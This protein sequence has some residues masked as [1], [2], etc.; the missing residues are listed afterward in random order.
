MNS[1]K[2]LLLILYSIS[3]VVFSQNYNVEV[4]TELGVNSTGLNI[5][6][7]DNG[8]FRVIGIIDSILNSI[9]FDAGGNVVG[10]KTFTDIDYNILVS[11]LADDGSLYF[12][13]YIYES[14]TTSIYVT[15]LNVEF[16]VLFN[17]KLDVSSPVT[18][19]FNIKSLNNGAILAGLDNSG[20]FYIRIGSNGEI[21]WKRS[22]YEL[23]F[24]PLRLALVELRNK[25]FIITTKRNIYRLNSNG[26]VL[27]NYPNYGKDPQIVELSDSSILVINQNKIFKLSN[28]GVIINEIENDDSNGKLLLTLLDDDNLFLHSVDYHYLRLIDSD[29]NIIWQIPTEASFS[30]A[31]I[32]NGVYYATGTYGNNMAVCTSGINEFNDK[33]IFLLEPNGSEVFL[34]PQ[35]HSFNRNWLAWESNLVDSIIIEYSHDNGLNWQ[36]LTLNYDF[37]ARYYYIDEP[38]V[39]SDECL[40]KIYDA[41]DP[42]FSDVSRNVFSTRIYNSTDYIAANEIFMW[43]GNNGM[44]A[45]DADDDD[46]G[47]FWPGGENATTAAVFADGIVWGCKTDNEIRVN[48]ATYRYGLTPGAILEDGTA[49]DKYDPNFQVFKIKKDWQTSS[50][51]YDLQKYG[52][53]YNNWPGKYGAPYIDVDGDDTYTAG[54]DEPEI[55]GDETLFYVANDLDTAQSKFTYGSDPIG[56]EFQQTI[57]A[58]NTP[59]LK[60]AV[61]KKV[62]II[63]KSGKV[64]EDMYITYWAD[65]DLGFAGDDFIGCDSLLNLAYT[66]N[67]DNYDEDYYGEAPPAVGHIILTGSVSGNDTLG[68][69]SFSPNFKNIF[70]LPTDLELGRYSGTLKFYNIMQGLTDSGDTLINPHNQSSTIFPLAGD[71]A[72]GTGWYE[73]EGW[74]DG[75]S[76]ADRRYTMSSGPFDMQPDDTQEVVYAI[77]MARGT[78][79]LNSVTKLKEKARELHEFWGNDI[80][81]SIKESGKHIPLQYSLSQNYPNPFNPVTTIEY[82]IPALTLSLS[83]RERVS[84]GRVRVTLK[85]YDILGR[86]VVT[87]VNER[88]KPGSYKVEFN[89]VSLASGLYFYQLQT[90]SY[91]KTNKMILIK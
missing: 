42:S 73:G 58:Y 77:F 29:F 16:S 8:K 54:I 13:Y 52:Y 7:N 75:P 39:N 74:P 82:S 44:S 55:I 32:V 57:Y 78:D 89:G 81:T 5:T 48:G 66:Y 79:N 85:I 47:L 90:G 3:S 46:S 53:N 61:F 51:M 43:I 10:T 70:G 76:S 26:E 2:I 38:L 35:S 21:I 19:C 88:Q 36:K 65:D 91:S 12:S 9:T 33:Y 23:G 40:I 62:K 72:T 71:P 22:F 31:K 34:S 37:S 67:G 15:R 20:Y 45:H 11:D 25:D 68:M 30:D 69:T 80:P 28:T 27:W 60:D 24:L 41:F 86:E 18:K 1:V 4:Y 17:I 64:L 14:D 50:S 84:D 83:P 56:I 59:V 49:G 87:L 63:N 6:K